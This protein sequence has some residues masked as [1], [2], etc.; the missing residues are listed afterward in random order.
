MNL[1]CSFI[2]ASVKMRICLLVILWSEGSI[3][4]CRVEYN[5][6]YCTFISCKGCL[7][8]FL[9]SRVCEAPTGLILTFLYLLIGNP[10]YYTNGTHTRYLDNC[11][12]QKIERLVALGNNIPLLSALIFNKVFLELI[13]GWNSNAGCWGGS[14][15]CC[16]TWV[17]IITILKILLCL[18]FDNIKSYNVNLY[19]SQV[20]SYA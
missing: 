10:S 4:L 15:N 1:H 3:H 11:I 8:L 5:H 2:H 17:N 18:F 19:S 13:R 7:M 14:S 9:P 20:S 16:F 12:M 6:V